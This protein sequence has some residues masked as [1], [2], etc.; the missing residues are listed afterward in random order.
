MNFCYVSNFTQGGVD[1]YASISIRA[2]FY[3]QQPDYC[4]DNRDDFWGYA[5]VEWEVQHVDVHLE[6]TGELIYS[7]SCQ[8]VERYGITDE[9]IHEWLFEQ[10]EKIGGEYD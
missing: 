8:D 4:A 9:D 1:C 7:E 2:Y 5:D 10:M 3:V 6:E